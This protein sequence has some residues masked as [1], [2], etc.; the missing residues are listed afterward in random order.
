[1]ARAHELFMSVMLVHEAFCSQKDFET[2]CDTFDE[3][4]VDAFIFLTPTDA[5][6]SAA[7]HAPVQQPRVLVTLD[8]RRGGHPHRH[9]GDPSPRINA[10]WRWWASTSG[11]R[12]PR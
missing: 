2:L 10:R 4:N 11:G 7:C 5:M 12:W 1:M 6:F 8:A 3:Q 9:G